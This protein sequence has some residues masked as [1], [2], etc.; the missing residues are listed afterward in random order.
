[1][2][3][4]ASLKENGF[5][6]VCYAL[7]AEALIIGYLGFTLLF[8]VETLLPT[9]VTARF[10]LT[11]F[12]FV[13]VLLSFILAALGRYLDISF[14]Q[15]INKKSPMLWL[16]L[17]WMLG[18]LAISL[19]KFPPLAIPIIIAGFFLIGFLFWKILFGEEK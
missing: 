8:T 16:G 11:T 14:E 17:F 10:S 4:L 18:I 15:K 2:R 3:H 5:L 9:F 1:M 7:L 19:Y 13:L 6:A 12:L